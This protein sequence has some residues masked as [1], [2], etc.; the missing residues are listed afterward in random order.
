MAGAGNSRWLFPL[1]ITYIIK[2]VTVLKASYH[3]QQMKRVD[4]LQ[5]LIEKENS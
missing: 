2:T 5:K 3:S 4:L 1:I